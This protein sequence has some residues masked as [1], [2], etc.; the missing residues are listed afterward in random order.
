MMRRITQYCA[1]GSAL[2]FNFEPTAGEKLSENLN[3][4]IRTIN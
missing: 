3:V 1:I 2:D 4:A